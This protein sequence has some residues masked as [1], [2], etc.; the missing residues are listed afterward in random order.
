MWSQNARRRPYWSLGLTW[1]C[2]TWDCGK[3]PT[4]SLLIALRLEQSTAL[5]WICGPQV[6]NRRQGLRVYCYSQCLKI[7]LLYPYLRTTRIHHPSLIFDYSCDG[8][9]DLCLTSWILHMCRCAG[10]HDALR[11]ATL[12]C[13]HRQ[14]GL[15][16]S[17]DREL[18]PLGR[19][20]G[21]LAQATQGAHSRAE[22]KERPLKKVYLSWY[23]L[24]TIVIIA[25]MF[26][27]L[28]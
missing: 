8:S 19:A 17:E 27:L 15:E 14:W 20:L 9:L 18:Q 7:I 3:G 13:T 24:L 22:R 10:I 21:F 5:P 25:K 26:L 11:H 28:L 1:Y 12:L 6:R 2:S 16:K 23:H 4:Y